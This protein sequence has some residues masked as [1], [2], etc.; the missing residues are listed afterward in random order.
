MSIGIYILV[1]AYVIDYFLTEAQR[2]HITAEEYM[3]LHDSWNKKIGIITWIGLAA[4]FLLIQNGSIPERIIEVT[5]LIL[6]S[7]IMVVVR[8]RGLRTISKV[9]IEGKYREIAIQ[10]VILAAITL[11]AVFISCTI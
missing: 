5:V 3:R 7:L 11:L 10:R 8:V 2:K 1:A 6:A 4:A 9:N